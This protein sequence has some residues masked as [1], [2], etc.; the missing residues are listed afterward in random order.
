[1]GSR[2]RA[3][4][5]FWVVGRRTAPRTCGCGRLHR[6]IT[7]LTDRPGF[8]S[9][10]H[11]AADCH[12]FYRHGAWP[13]SSAPA[14]SPREIP[15]RRPAC[16]RGGA[17]PS[18]C[19]RAEKQHEPRGQA[20]GRSTTDLYG[21][22]TKLV[23]PAPAVCIPPCSWI[24][25]LRRRTT[26]SSGGR[27]KPGQLS[28]EQHLGTK[29]TWGTPATARKTSTRTAAGQP[30]LRYIWLP[31]CRPAGRLISPWMKWLGLMPACRLTPWNHQRVPA[32]SGHSR[33]ADGDG[34][35]AHQKTGAAEPRET[36]SATPIPGAPPV[37]L[38]G[39]FPRRLA[40][41]PIPGH[42]EHPL[43]HLGLGRRWPPI[44]AGLSNRGEPVWPPPQ[45]APTSP[46]STIYRR[47][48]SATRRVRARLHRSVPLPPQQTF[49][50]VPSTE[51]QSGCTS[52]GGSM[53]VGRIQPG[54]RLRRGPGEDVRR[55]EKPALTSRPK[56]PCDRRGQI[57]KSWFLAAG[58]STGPFLSCSPVGR[59]TSEDVPPT[60]K[61][62]SAPY[63]E[64][65]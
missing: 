63:V 29:Q 5:A 24:N 21:P 16:S 47:P 58:L 13:D 31:R 43:Y 19:G 45:R 44:S 25:R 27:V 62:R 64:P 20:A 57:P 7:G 51:P 6:T 53:R 4:P 52:E 8:A 56:R 61:T 2:C 36:P 32:A 28:I 15:C 59:Q 14:P 12:P 11:R 55:A 33:D 42:V 48:A 54:I 10:P 1:M 35:P 46:P 37:D 65:T 60:K 3:T 39:D 9:T 40:A 23:S 17:F 49:A 50:D 34:H 41:S 26:S 18:A 30:R 38:C 22:Y